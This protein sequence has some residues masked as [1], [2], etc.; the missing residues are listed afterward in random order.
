MT[1]YDINHFRTKNPPAITLSS[2]SGSHMMMD[3]LYIEEN[4]D[5]LVRKLFP[6]IDPS[7]DVT[8]VVYSLSQTTDANPCIGGKSLEDNPAE[9]TDQPKEEPIQGQ[10]VNEC[11][12]PS[13]VIGSSDDASNISVSTHKNTPSGES[14]HQRNISDENRDSP[15]KGWS[16]FN[17]LAIL[18]F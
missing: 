2:G 12:D 16:I 8:E 5:M 9:L 3:I 4:F 18:K 17:F 6:F 10:D 14:S 11:I 7:S 13:H 15:V 1:T